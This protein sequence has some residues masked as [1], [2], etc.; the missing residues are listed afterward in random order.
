MAR[1][2]ATMT[3]AYE[4]WTRGE[5]YDRF[6]AGLSGAERAAVLL[7][8]LYQQVNNG[9]FRQ[10]VDN[11]YGL[12]AGEVM[13]LCRLAGPAGAAVADEVARIAPRIDFSRP[14]R[15]FA[16][17]YW[18]DEGPGEDVLDACDGRFYDLDEAF[19]AEVDDLLGRLAS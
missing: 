6:L 18:L 8:N 19:V 13:S 17:D 16:G 5:G 9:G 1:W 15:G 7:G 10:W 14:N 12:H 4:R 11:G 3:A 2:Q